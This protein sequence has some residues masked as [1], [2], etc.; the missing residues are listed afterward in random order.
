MREW[1]E[2]PLEFHAY[3]IHSDKACLTLFD[4]NCPAFFAPNERQDYALFLDEASSDYVVVKWDGEVVGA[5]GL[6]SAADDARLNWIMVDPQRKGLG[7]GRAIMQEATA[8]ARHLGA[9]AIHI[10]AS[11]LS[12]PFFAR[13][14]ARQ[15]RYAED[16]WGPGMHRIDMVLP[17]PASCRP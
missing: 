8:R 14:G 9:G 3:D 10:A 5:F 7:V 11:H 13:F 12:A 4:A 1:G 6:F 16:G 15:T 17:V 2:M